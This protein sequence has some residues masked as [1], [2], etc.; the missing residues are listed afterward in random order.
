MLYWNKNMSPQAACPGVHLDS[1]FDVAWNSSKVISSCSPIY[2]GPSPF[3]EPETRAI[4][5]VLHH[6]SNRIIA[7]IHVHAGSHGDTTYKV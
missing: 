2:A 7:Y 6:Y 3:S 4:R 1:N 5:D